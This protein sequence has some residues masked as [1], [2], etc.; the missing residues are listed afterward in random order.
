MLPKQGSLPNGR[1][2]GIDYGLKRIGVAVSD[3]SQTIVSGLPTVINKGWQK[4]IDEIKNL[5][6]NWNIV[7][8]VV[9]MPFN[10]DGSKSKFCDNVEFFITR[11]QQSL[12]IPIFTWDERMTTLAAER[13]MKDTNRSPSR[14]KSV[15]DQLAAFFILQSFLDYMSS[16]Q[17]QSN[18][19]MGN[20]L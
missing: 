1:V 10:M 17:K 6:D 5:V 15:V 8:I 7:A 3:P 14:G 4:T 18:P 12:S 16:T 11:L 19:E 9:G 2:L 13:A 20:E